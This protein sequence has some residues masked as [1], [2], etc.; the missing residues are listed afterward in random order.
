[1][2][3]LRLLIL[4]ALISGTPV[5]A[6]AQSENGSASLTVR[7]G[8]SISTVSPMRLQPNEPGVSLSV[9]GSNPVDAP[10]MIQISGDP[11]RVYRIRLPQGEADQDVAVIEDLKIW[12]ANSGDISETRVARLDLQGHDLLRVSGRLRIRLGDEGEPI[13]ALPLSIDYE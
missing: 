3:P 6:A 7:R 13:A 2:K 8:L 1:M 10:A 9:T 11:G 12:S 4:T 5:A